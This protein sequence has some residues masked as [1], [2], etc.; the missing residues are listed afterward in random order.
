[1]P[2]T[3]RPRG[4]ALNRTVG[5]E[6]LVIDIR[7]IQKGS[8]D[9]LC[10]DNLHQSSH[11]NQK[12]QLHFFVKII[13]NLLERKEMKLQLICC[14]I[15]GLTIAHKASQCFEQG[16]LL[17]GASEAVDGIIDSDLTELTKLTP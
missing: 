6:R 17:G 12:F 16:K 11:C 14:F 8:S 13:N 1:M 2:A 4:I 3:S 5:V 10:A 7:S 9:A 15:L